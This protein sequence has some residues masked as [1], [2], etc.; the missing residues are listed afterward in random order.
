MPYFILTAALTLLGS[1]GPAAMVAADNEAPYIGQYSLDT[2]GGDAM[3]G[4]HLLLFKGG[5]YAIVYFGGM[6]QGTW[7]VLPNGELQL[8]E[9]PADPADFYVYG[10]YSPALAGQ[11][12]LTFKNFEESLAKVGFVAPGS[13]PL[14]MHP[15]FSLQANGFT[16]DYSLKRK[17]AET[18]AIYL[19]AY[20]DERI[21]PE[22]R[23]PVTKSLLYTFPL[24][25]RYNEYL[26]VYNKM[27]SIPATRYIGRFANKQLTLYSTSSE[28]YPGGDAYGERYPIGA[29]DLKEIPPYIKA[30]RAK[31]A[32]KLVYREG[33]EKKAVTCNRLASTSKPLKATDI[34]LLAPLFKTSYD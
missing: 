32:D 28:A 6:Q 4:V 23:V 30:A 15:A 27:A 8:D 18:P 5:D 26:I 7:K 19:A 33:P 9:W 13:G 25:K 24:D 29:S 20:Q 17:A 22:H 31:M 12:Q 16:S 10:T 34:K 14:P 3:S 21:K 11:I 2:G 1:L